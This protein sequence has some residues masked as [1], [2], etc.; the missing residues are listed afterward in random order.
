[1]EIAPPAIPFGAEVRYNIAHQFQA[2]VIMGLDIG[3][4]TKTMLPR[5]Q[6]AAY[7]F[8]WTLPEDCDSWGDGNAFGFYLRSHL[9]ARAANYIRAHPELDADWEG[10][11]EILDWIE[12]LPYD[13]VGYIELYFGW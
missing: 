10:Q 5:P 9:H 6:G 12:S 8:A 11:K 13:D 1:M 3:T 4:V 2:D 7:D